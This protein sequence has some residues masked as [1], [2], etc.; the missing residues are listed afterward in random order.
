MR[1][2]VITPAELDEESWAALAPMAFRGTTV[3]VVQIPSALAADQS[4]ADLTVL[5]AAITAEGVAAAEQGYDAICIDHVADPGIDALRSRLRIPVVGSGQAAVHVAAMVGSRNTLISSTAAARQLGKTWEHGGGLAL[6]PETIRSIGSGDT[7]ALLEKIEAAV[8]SDS[9]H[10]VILGESWM[11]PSIEAARALAG[12]TIVSASAAAIKLAESFVSLGVAHSELAPGYNASDQALVGGFDT[13]IPR[14]V[15]SAGEPAATTSFEGSANSESDFAVKIIVPVQGLTEHELKLRALELS[16]GLLAPGTRVGY[17]S[18]TDSSDSAD[19][20]YDAF[21]LTLFCFEEGLRAEEQGYDAVLTHSTTDSG[22]EA[23]RSAVQIPVIGAGEACWNLAAVLG[24]KFSIIAMEKKWNH[25]FSK[26]TQR[27]GVWRR[28]A[29]VVD[30]G[31]APDPVLLFEGKE[32]EMEEALGRV[33]QEAIEVDSAD[34][35]VIGSTTMQMAEE[36]LS[37]TLPAP[38]LSP[39]MVA[40]KAAESLG[41]MG[42]RHSS[43]AHPQSGAFDASA[44]FEPSAAEGCSYSVPAA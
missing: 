10:A 29:S 18:L 24:N 27:A 12:A 41:A 38:V 17:H 1:I 39:G 13:L 3:D 4:A 21:L 28:L 5:G 23:M 6:Y 19:C 20:G 34:T 7:A 42:L 9:G 32:R 16:E 14:R 22:I 26:G 31:I 44:V 33:A 2:K 30:I 35:F 15:R 11:A 40:L 36:Y 43:R 8:E 37:E 25:F